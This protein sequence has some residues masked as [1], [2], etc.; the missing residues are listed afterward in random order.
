MTTEN[1]NESRWTEITKGLLL[2]FVALNVLLHQA[3]VAGIGGPEGASQLMMWIAVFGVVSYAVVRQR[4]TVGYW[5]SILTGILSLVFTGVILSGTL[6]ALPTGG[7]LVGFVL[8]PIAGAAYPLVLIVVT[9]LALRERDGT[10]EVRAMSD[11]GTAE[12]H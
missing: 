7:S 8:G 12:A 10:D 2:G 9:I 6:G 11:D 5:L 1:T 4:L 3:F